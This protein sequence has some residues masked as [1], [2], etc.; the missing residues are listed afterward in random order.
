MGF[1][2]E[3]NLDIFH[4]FLFRITQGFFFRRFFKRFIQIFFPGF[5]KDFTRFFSRISFLSGIPPAT[6]RV[7]I[8]WKISCGYP[9]LL[10][11]NLPPR[12]SFWDSSRD[13]SRLFSSRVSSETLQG[14]LQEFSKVITQRFHSGFPQILCQYASRKF[15][16]RPFPG[17][18]KK[19]LTK[20]L[21]AYFSRFFLRFFRVFFSEFLTGFSSGIL[22]DISFGIPPKTLLFFFYQDPLRE[23]FQGP[24][25]KKSTYRDSI[26][27]GSLQK[28]NLKIPSISVETPLGI[29]FTILPT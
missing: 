2:L 24:V 6:R 21:Q 5:L 23:V 1:L 14:C 16:Y 11:G 12:P 8:P 20:F 27:H 7:I 10:V 26:A 22:L 15:L 29:N 25:L 28:W 18:F 3:F 13:S 4:G 19:L 9:E 17:F